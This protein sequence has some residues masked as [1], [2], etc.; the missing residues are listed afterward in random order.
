MQTNNDL[1]F[2]KKFNTVNL[3]GSFN[4]E[5]ISVANFFHFSLMLKWTGTPTGVFKLQGSNDDSTVEDWEDITGSNFSTLGAA[6]QVV[7][8]YD[9]A[10]FRWL[11]V[12]Y[13]FT[14]GTGTLI[15]ANLTQKGPY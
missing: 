3:S 7:F 14:S 8:N 9:T 2:D 10:P 12:V 4:S 6:G 13:T 11:R 1:I 5:Q 15:K